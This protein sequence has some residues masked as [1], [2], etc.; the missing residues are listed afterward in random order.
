MVSVVMNTVSIIILFLFARKIY[1]HFY[2]QKKESFKYA[3]YAYIAMA[4][5]LIAVCHEHEP[6]VINYIL[7]VMAINIYNKIFYKTNGY[8]YILFNLS[9]LLFLLLVEFVSVIII[10]LMT[11]KTINEYLEKGNLIS[12]YLINWFVMLAILEPGYMLLKRKSE[13][14]P[15]ITISGI[16]AY[17]SLFVFEIVMI[18]YTTKLASD[19]KTTTI[20]IVTLCG[21]TFINLL[22]AYLIFKT[23]KNSE[24]QYENE[25]LQQQSL[26]Q[27]TLY[28]DLLKKYELSHETIHDVRKHLKSLAGLIENESKASQYIAEYLK[29]IE[30]IEPQF[31]SKNEILNIIINHKMFQGKDKGI[32]LKVDYGNVDMSFISDIDITVMLANVLDNAFEA[33]ES[34]DESNREVK[35][36]ITS[37]SNFLLINISNIYLTVDQRPDG[38]FEST[39]KNHSGLGL[40][41]VQKA[42]E[43]YDGIYKAEVA[44]DKFK[45][46]ITIPIPDS[47]ERSV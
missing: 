18:G 6:D 46:K 30:Q 28:N 36:I 23:A 12:S 3:E 20:L 10:P 35:L 25:L 16:A 7:V 26:M 31:K 21:Y 9:A 44:D 32:A 43:K 24:I 4:S 13:K 37:M 45:V 17:I 14:L 47:S 1:P 40:K 34:L 29:E 22:A 41:N 38:K 5:I 39:K 11:H 19:K 2:P 42:V 27:I 33:V 15:S 8:L